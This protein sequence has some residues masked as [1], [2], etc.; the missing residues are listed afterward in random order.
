MVIEGSVGVTRKPVLIVPLWTFFLPFR[1]KG[2]EEGEVDSWLWMGE[3]IG[4]FL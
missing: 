4:G 1:K 2:K 3:G